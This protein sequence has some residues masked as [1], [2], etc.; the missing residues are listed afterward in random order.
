MRT[1][2]QC[3]V[4]TVLRAVIWNWIEDSPDEFIDVVQSPRRGLEGNP[5]RVFDLLYQLVDPGNKPMFWPTLSVLLTISPERL[6]A[7]E[8]ARSG[9]SR[10]A[11]KVNLISSSSEMFNLLFILSSKSNC[12]NSYMGL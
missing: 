10:F 9:T 11:K 12:S 6:R 8:M 5:E 1:E 4:A 3:A 2:T 7:A